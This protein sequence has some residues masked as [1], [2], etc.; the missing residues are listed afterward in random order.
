MLS[1]RVLGNLEESSST[2]DIPVATG[3]VASLDH[4]ALA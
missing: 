2:E 3:C 4:E 1:Q